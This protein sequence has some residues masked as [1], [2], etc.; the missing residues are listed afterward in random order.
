MHIGT[1]EWNMARGKGGSQ[2]EN[3]SEC[4]RLFKLPKYQ[5]AFCLFV[6]CCG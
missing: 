6:H 1:V 2:A 3:V 4:I 5:A